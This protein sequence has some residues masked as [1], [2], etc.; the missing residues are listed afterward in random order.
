MNLKGKV[1]RQFNSKNFVSIEG[2]ISFIKSLG[3]D[4]YEMRVVFN[5][6]LKDYS[7]EVHYYEEIQYYDE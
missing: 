4:F 3:P 1:F 2:A 6:S 5:I 7:F